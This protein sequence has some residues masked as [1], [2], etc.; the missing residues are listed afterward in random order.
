[1]VESENDP[2]T[3]PTIFWFNG[4]P[5]CSSLD[6]FMYELGPFIINP[7][8]T[9]STRP[10]RWNQL[11]NMVYIESPVGVGF[12]YSNSL[13]Y[14]TDDDRTAQ[15]N[16]QAI[17]LFFTEKFPQLKANKFFIAGESYAGIYGKIN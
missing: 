2:V 4:G 16:K 9:L 7:N 1:M 13:S 11:A 15:E 10:G 3:D 12:S 17:S 8:L 5:G 14:K 6:G